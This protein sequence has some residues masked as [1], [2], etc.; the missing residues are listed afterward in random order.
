MGGDS[1]I[2]GLVAQLLFNLGFNLVADRLKL[3]F[4]NLANALGLV[5][6]IYNKVFQLFA[7][8]LFAAVVVA[9]A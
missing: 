2:C 3:L 1:V 9:G 6:N 7:D 5:A 4:Q 8:S